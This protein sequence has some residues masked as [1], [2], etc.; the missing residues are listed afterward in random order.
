MT[1]EDEQKAIWAGRAKDYDKIQWTTNDWLLREFVSHCPPA[2]HVLDVGTG[3][4][5]VASALAGRSR[6]IA[7]IDTSREMLVECK[8]KA[9][10]QNLTF[11]E[12]DVQYLP[13]RLNGSFDLATA[14]MVFHHVEDVDRGLAE[15]YR[16]LKPGGSLV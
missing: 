5:I 3:T 7:C 6:W 9:D 8:K 1:W 11:D 14:R 12:I 16:V 15:V 2:D 4:G 13:L 10:L